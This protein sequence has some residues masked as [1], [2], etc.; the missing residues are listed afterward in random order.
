MK[1]TVYTSSSI[2]PSAM[3]V[4]YVPLPLSLVRIN[5]SLFSPAPG[6]APAE[7]GPPAT[8][9]GAEAQPSQIQTR[10]LRQALLGRRS[11]VLV[12]LEAIS[13]SCH[14]GDRG[15]LGSCWFS[16]VLEPDLQSENAS[17]EKETLPRSQRS[18]FP[19]GGGEPDLGR[20]A[21]SWRT[22]DAGP[23]SIGANHLPL[24]EA[25]TQRPDVASMICVQPNGSARFHFIRF[26]GRAHQTS[27]R[28]SSIMMTYSN[29]PPFGEASSLFSYPVTAMQDHG[30]NL[31]FPHGLPRTA[32]AVRGGRTLCSQSGRV[33]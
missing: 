13:H 3:T 16:H 24:D 10:S 30:C 25:C 4:A 32:A 5:C 27:L 23:R 8:T 2:P 20:T 33:T 15:P 1:S 29:S 11:L 26:G 19:D 9:H 17:G 7:S 21:D 6:P 22:S 18:D 12:R 31:A 14:A 28:S